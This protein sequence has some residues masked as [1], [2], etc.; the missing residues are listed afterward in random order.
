MRRLDRNGIRQVADGPFSTLGE[1]LESPNTDG[2]RKRL[3]KLRLY[4]MD[5]SAEAIGHETPPW[6]NA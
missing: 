1:N 4:L 2:V 3:E 5:G 6:R